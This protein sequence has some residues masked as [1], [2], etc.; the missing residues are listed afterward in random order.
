M[1]AVN[2]QLVPK[3]VFQLYLS[4]EWS[5]C[6]AVFCEPV[7]YVAAI[8]SPNLIGVGTSAH[9]P[10]PQYTTLC[11]P[12]SVDDHVWSWCSTITHYHQLCVKWTSLYIPAHYTVPPDQPSTQ[13]MFGWSTCVLI[14]LYVYACHTS[15]SITWMHD[16]VLS[17]TYLLFLPLKVGWEWRN[18]QESAR[19]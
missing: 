18:V 4:G 1:F 8:I 6:L 2:W 14:V 12:L 15:G 17:M 11:A 5:I 19:N 3:C 7:L 13:D 10:N 16:F 9:M